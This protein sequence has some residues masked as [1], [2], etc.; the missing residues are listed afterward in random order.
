MISNNFSHCIIKNIMFQDSE[1]DTHTLGFVS[2]T[3]PPSVEKDQNTSFNPATLS[4]NIPLDNANSNKPVS[5]L[6][7][8]SIISQIIFFY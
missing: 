7:L 1:K 2:P 8:L 5:N 4:Y 6:C 3:S